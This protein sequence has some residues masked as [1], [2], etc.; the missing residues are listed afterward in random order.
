MN[1]INIFVYVLT[2]F[3]YQNQDVEGFWITEDDV[4]GKKKSEVLIYKEGNKVYGKIINLLLQED[5]G[6]LCLKCKGENKNK[7]IEGLLILKD[8]ILEEDTWEGGT[9]LAPKSGKIYDCYITLEDD[10]TLKVR[11]FL[12]FSLLGRTQIWKRK[13]D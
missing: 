8:L 6:K 13:L 12:G 10:N 1:A 3:F 5:K 9:I 2:I 11:G 4:T 7:P